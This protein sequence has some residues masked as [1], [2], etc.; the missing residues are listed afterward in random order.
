M[1]SEVKNFNLKSREVKNAILKYLYQSSVN[2][3]L[4]YEKINSDDDIMQIKNNDYIVCP[5]VVGVRSWILFLKI[6][7][8]YYAVNFPKHGERKKE[9]LKIHP[10]E[11]CVSKT[12]Y[13]GTIMEGIFYKNENKKYLI[14]DEV[15][16]LAGENQLIKSKDDRLFNLVNI[17]QQMIQ[18]NPQYLIHVSKFYNIN[19]VSLLELYNKVKIDNSIQELI[20]YPKLHGRKIYSYTIMEDDLIDDI[21]KISQFIMQKTPNPDVYNLLSLTDN[22]KIDIAYIPN[23]ECSKKCKQWYREHKTN[24]LTI[25]CQFDSIKK[26]WIPNKICNM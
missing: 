23:M 20:F 12:L 15:Y 22:T 24:E 19:K 1:N 26:K 13:R 11:L 8:H 21:I 16:K 17:F 6:N 3:E 4:K 5:R 10:I 14:I 7:E 2:L 9:S 18:S 25:E